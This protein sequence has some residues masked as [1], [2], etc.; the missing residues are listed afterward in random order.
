[1]KRV[2]SVLTLAGLL[3]T[4]AFANSAYGQLVNEPFSYPDGDLVGN[5]SW[6]AHSGATT[7]TVS[8]GKAVVN[9]A[10]S[11]DVNKPI[12]ATLGAGGTFYAA[13][14]V[15]ISASGALAIA[16]SPTPTSEY[17]AHF[18]DDTTAGGTAFR[19]RIFATGISGSDYTFGL[20]ATSGTNP[21]STW[22]TGF[23]FGSTQRVVVAFAYDTGLARLWVNPINELST[24]I[25]DTGGAAQ[26]IAAFALRQS[27]N[28][29]NP[30]PSATVDNLCIGTEFVQA[31]DCVPEPSTIALL[32]FGAV[33]LLR[34]RK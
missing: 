16:G 9:M 19:G 29:T 25:S 14:D 31:L 17:F 34:R 26:A 15:S 5:D 8:G 12:G 22:A 33:A 28:G 2:Q 18:K 1:M 13:L 3:C 27:A 7:V 24:N 6:T 10:N 21:A 20:R 4:F 23:T 11:Q 32:G 30:D